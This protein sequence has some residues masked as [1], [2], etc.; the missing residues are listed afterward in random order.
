ML[1]RITKSP[2]PSQNRDSKESF[3]QPEKFPGQKEM[4]KFSKTVVYKALSQNI[5]QLRQQGANQEN[6]GFANYMRILGIERAERV[7]NLWEVNSIITDY[8]D[9]KLP[10]VLGKETN[11]IVG[12][13][14]DLYAQAPELEDNYLKQFV[15]QND[16]KSWSVQENLIARVQ[17]VASLFGIKP[18]SFEVLTSFANYVCE[19]QNPDLDRQ[20]RLENY[21]QDYPF[22]TFLNG[23]NNEVAIARQKLENDLNAPSYEKDESVG[24]LS[25]PKQPES[26]VKTSRSTETKIS[27]GGKIEEFY[28]LYRDSIFVD[29]LF[30]KIDYNDFLEKSGSNEE[31]V[32]NVKSEKNLIAS[33]FIYE[34]QKK[35]EKDGY[36]T[37][38]AIKC[39]PSGYSDISIYTTKVD[40]KGNKQKSEVQIQTNQTVLNKEKET[41]ENNVRKEILQSIYKQNSV[42]LESVFDNFVGENKKYQIQKAIETIFGK[43]IGVN[44]PDPQDVVKIIGKEVV[45]IN[46]EF[47]A[48]NSD[49]YASLAQSLLDN[50]DA[51][52]A[53]LARSQSWFSEGS[54]IQNKNDVDEM[55]SNI[56]KLARESAENE[57]LQGTKVQ[58]D[59]TASKYLLETRD[60]QAIVKNQVAQTMKKYESRAKAAI[61]LPAKTPFGENLKPTARAIFWH[62]KEN[63]VLLLQKLPISKAPNALE[64]PGGKIEEEDLMIND[65]VIPL[66]EQNLLNP[67]YR[68]AAEKAA[69]REL[70]EEVGWNSEGKWTKKYPDRSFGGVQL[71]GAFSYANETKIP[72]TPTIVN[73]ASVELSNEPFGMEIGTMPEDKHNPRFAKWVTV[74]QIIVAQA[75]GFMT[76]GNQTFPLNGNLRLSPQAMWELNAQA[77]SREDMIKERR[78]DWRANNP[79]F[80]RLEALRNS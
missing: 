25:T 15:A 44:K 9:T 36:Q 42:F 49:S 62:P 69:L 22:L 77:K 35:L 12:F 71:N 78:E 28:D 14:D 64:F 32:Q 29:Q 11:K 52:T 74:E 68:E 66:E 38:I 60:N 47:K 39:Y 40:E 45:K 24:I 34:T 8:N 46:P 59:P 79:Y 21:I 58:N 37:K 65:E 72:P 61:E 50:F 30:E 76:I 51:M 10:S 53:S 48:E 20:I 33:K 56:E 3:G 13:Y 57:I 18:P 2:Q 16:Y 26:G 75:T 1:E 5:N 23:S 73:L 19:R 41:P 67:K 17:E 6:R 31:F 27:R 55:M 70:R 7:K 4:E 63:K 54:F 80:E 43:M